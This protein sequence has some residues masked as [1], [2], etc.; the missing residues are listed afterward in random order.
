M[1]PDDY[2]H[3]S[4]VE[5]M[6]GRFRIGGKVNIA[7]PR[8]PDEAKYSGVILDIDYVD[9]CAE[10]MFDEGNRIDYFNFSCLE[11]EGY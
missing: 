5:Q 7:H 3:D 6:Q 1:N 10:V 8:F 4:D 9:E 11:K 2:I